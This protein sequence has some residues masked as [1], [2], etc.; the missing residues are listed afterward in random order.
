[1]RDEFSRQP[2]ALI[3]P[4]LESPSMR[5]NAALAHE[6]LRAIESGATD[7]LAQ[8]LSPD[9]VYEELPNRLFPAGRRSTLSQMRESAAKGREI[10]VTQHYEVLN[11]IVQGEWVVLEIEWV[12]SLKIP[13]GTIPAGKPLRDRSAIV[14]KFR[15]G[16]ITHQRNYDC[17][18]PW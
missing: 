12:G 10:L 17:Y 16:K 5:D 15:D 4:V 6:Y 1:M 18:D 14:L 13:F 2:S 9:I 3:P 11:T 8:F 7:P